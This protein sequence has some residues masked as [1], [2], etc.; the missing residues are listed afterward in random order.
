VP[1]PTTLTRA[2]LTGVGN[3][4]AACT[5]LFSSTNSGRPNICAIYF[6]YL[7]VMLAEVAVADRKKYSNIND[8]SQGYAVHI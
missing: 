4:F 7:E 2:P 3:L 1:Q 8:S 6:N 5:L